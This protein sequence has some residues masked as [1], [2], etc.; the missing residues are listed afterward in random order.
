MSETLVRKA[1][2]QHDRIAQAV[3]SLRGQVVTQKRIVTAYTVAFPDATDFRWV[4]ASDHA[5][6][7]TNSGT[8]RCSKT[9]NAL[10]DRIAHGNYFVRPILGAAP[11]ADFRE[12]IRR[13][14]QALTHGPVQ[15]PVGVI[16]P[17]VEYAE[18]SQFYRDPHVRAWVLQRAAGCCELCNEPAPFLTDSENAFL[19]SHHIIALSDDGPDIPE[20]TSALCPN[21]HRKM[22]YSKERVELREYL[23]QVIAAKEATYA[24]GRHL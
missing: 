21:C 6:N 18:T 23:K 4:Q 10:F 19:E 17:K 24:S 14:D 16:K 8:C 12:Y 3:A 2:E 15:R 11:T 9:E 7:H 13:A 20:N 1:T 22:H 5:T